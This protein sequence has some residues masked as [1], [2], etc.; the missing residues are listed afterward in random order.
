MATIQE[1]K[2]EMQE[3]VNAGYLLS[4]YFYK[5]SRKGLVFIGVSEQ[6]E[7]V[8]FEQYPDPCHESDYY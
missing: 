3:M 6:G 5:H 8:Y 4:F 1:I 2:Q 7:S